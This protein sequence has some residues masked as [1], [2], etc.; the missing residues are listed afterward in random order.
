MHRPPKQNQPK[1]RPIFSSPLFLSAY[2]N[3]LEAHDP[4]TGA[5]DYHDWL[6]RKGFDPIT[7]RMTEEGLAFF[8]ALLRKARRARIFGLRA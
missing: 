8:K 4:D 3:A 6:H 5:G 7:G 2:A 1:H